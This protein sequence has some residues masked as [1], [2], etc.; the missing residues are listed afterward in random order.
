MTE[1]AVRGRTS[2]GPGELARFL[3]VERR[4]FDYAL[5]V[6]IVPGPDR[7]SRRQRRWTHR[8]AVRLRRTAPEIRACL[9]PAPEL[10][11]LGAVRSAELLADRLGHDVDPCV[12]P[13]LALLG[14]VPRAGYYRGRPLYD[15]RAVDVVDGDLV[16]A[17]ALTGRLVMGEEAARYL[18]IR[19]AD[20]DHLVRAGRL[21][22]ATK[23]RSRYQR[24]RSAP[25]VALYRIGDL[26]E[27]T[28][29]DRIDWPAVRDTPRGR[30]SVLAS[31]PTA[32]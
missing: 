6:G 31:L 29:D 30:P 26:D 18:G 10:E 15:R 20:L 28:T 12:L 27:L 4:Q 1:T 19:A 14:H 23:V 22:P 9:P 25:A 11:H 5:A 7:H 13:E 24:R 2:Y 8:C 21:V 16:T 3:E 17:A 32:D